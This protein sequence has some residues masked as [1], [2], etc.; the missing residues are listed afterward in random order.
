[1]KLKWK[2]K[3]WLAIVGLI[4]I[5]AASVGPIM[6][7]V[8]TPDYTIEKADGAFEIRRYPDM[9][10]AEVTQSGERM[11]AIGD[12][13]SALAD[14]IF[15]ANEP[16][17]PIAM[18][19]PVTQQS[20]ELGDAWNVRFVMPRQYT[21][22]DLPKPKNTKVKLEEVPSRSVIVIRFSGSTKD[23]NVMAR[24]EDLKNYVAK[25]KLVVSGE[26]V[27]AFYNPPWTL[28]FLRRNEIWWELG[29]LSG[30]GE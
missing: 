22:A 23:E 26:P 28:P 12:G 16:K 2:K 24:M 4:G 1:M 14:F 3:Y 25:N 5:A 20:T 29:N 15:G 17:A 19:A 21:M 7:D 30:E 8:E 6:S 11:N 18:T 27:F 13:F 10:V 9:V